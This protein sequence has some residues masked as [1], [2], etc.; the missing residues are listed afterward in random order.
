MFHQR[1][2]ARLAMPVTIVFGSVLEVL[3]RRRW[4][5]EAWFDGD[6]TRLPT[7]RRY[8]YR[9]GTLV[10]RGRVVECLRPVRLT[11]YE[12]LVDSPCRVRLRLRWRLEPFDG[13]TSVLLDARYELNGPAYLNRRHWREQ[14]HGHCGRLLAAVRADL[15]DEEVGQGVAAVSGQ[16]IGSNTMT[17][18]NT[19]A[20]NGKP[21]FK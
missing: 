19:T 13:G 16:K 3:A 12:S 14:I 7:G 6:N 4:A 17:V 8:E 1:H 2:E 10:R 11:L 15:V 18:T 20:V 21:S 5:A 9:S